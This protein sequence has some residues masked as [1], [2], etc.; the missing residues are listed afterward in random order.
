MNIKERVSKF[1]IALF[2]IM[3]EFTTQLKRT[4]GIIGAYKESTG[5]PRR[6]IQDIYISKQV[7][8]SNKCHIYQSLQRK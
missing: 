4:I 6:H 2:A 3:V 7:S 1:V 8:R 5:N